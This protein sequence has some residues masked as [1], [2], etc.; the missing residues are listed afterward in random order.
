MNDAAA[1]VTKK[2]LA[3]NLRSLRRARG[4]SQIQVAQKASI[5]DRLYQSLESAAGNPTLETL[6][7]L[8][9]AL[10]VAY[11]DLLQLRC[12]RV[13]DFD[14][15]A[16]N[17]RHTCQDSQLA[18]GLVFADGNIAWLN[19]KTQKL[20]DVFVINNDTKAKLKDIIATCFNSCLMPNKWQSAD[21]MPEHCFLASDQSGYHGLRMHCTLIKA[22]K[23]HKCY[24]AAFVLTRI[25][26]ATDR[27][28]NEYLKL[29]ID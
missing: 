16:T 28:Y 24:G 19:P 21:F 9:L 12:L 14:A 7:S 10:E 13:N 23:E 2:T 29:L 5:S 1:V 27:T 15:F 4:L 3:G 26:E 22:P 8:S 18:A 11:T 6:A 20:F 17:F 25:G